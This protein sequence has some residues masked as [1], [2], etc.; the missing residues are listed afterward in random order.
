MPTM[1]KAYRH[2]PSAV[3]SACA[4]TL[5]ECGFTIEETKGAMIVA[6]SAPSVL[7]W[8]ERVVV[9]IEQ[10]RH[11]TTVSVESSPTAQLFDWG[12]SKENVETFFS[13][14]DKTLR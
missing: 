6:S 4:R 5:R 10:D 9:R 12:K 13:T 14:L 2:S 3:K 1:S 7:S 8:G 11:G